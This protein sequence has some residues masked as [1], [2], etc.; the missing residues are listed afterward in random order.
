MI[1]PFGVDHGEVSKAAN[2]ALNVF[3]GAGGTKARSL[4]HGNLHL[5]ALPKNP[6]SRKAAQAD[7]MK[8]YDKMRMGDAGMKRNPDLRKVSPAKAPRGTRG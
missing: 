2:K 5:R 6:T 1:S 3:M 8:P 4:T 7:M